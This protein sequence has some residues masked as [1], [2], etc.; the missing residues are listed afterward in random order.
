MWATVKQRIHQ[1]RGALIVAPAVAGALVALRLAGSLQLLELVALDQLFRLRPLEAADPRIVIVTIDEPDIKR[2]GRWPMSDAVLARLISLIKQQQP[3]AIGFDLF[4]NMPVEPGHQELLRIFASTKNLIGIEKVV[5]SAEGNT[6]EGPA[7]L[8]QRGQ[9]SASDFVLDIDGRLRRNLL[10]L[11]TENNQV[12]L[13]F[14]AKLAFTY[15]TSAGITPQDINLDKSQFRLGKAVFT[16]LQLNDGGYSQ[17]DAGG[18]QILSNF[19][20]LR[21][22]FHSISMTEV[23]QGQMPANLVRD[24]IVLIGSTAESV[25]DR[26]YTSFTVSP[27]TASAGV[28]VH[29]QLI[30]QL[31]SAAIEGRPL[32]RTWSEPLE[33]L[34]ILLWS[35]IG[36][37]WGWRFQSPRRTAIAVLL[38]GGVL[39]GVAYLLF[40][41]GWWLIVIPPSLALVTAASL[42]SGYQLWENLKLSHRQLADY[43][44]TLEQ[45]V[46]ERTEA[47]QQQKELL[48]TIVDHIPVMITLY[49]ADGRI[50]FINRELERCLG[51]S[52]VELESIDWLAECYLDPDQSQQNLEH[53]V[54]ATG[55]WLDLRIKAR[56]GDYLNITWANIPLSNG[57]SIGIGQDITERKQ[58]EEASILAS[59]L[60]ER[61]R[62]AREIHDTLA[63]TLTSIILQLEAAKQIV[64]EQPQAAQVH[65][66]RAGDF[67]RAGLAEAR[68]SVRALRPGVLEG[69]NLADALQRCLKQITSDGL[70]GAEF[71]VQGNSRPLAPDLEVELLRIGQEAMSNVLKHAQASRLSVELSFAADQVRLCIQD[72]GKGLELALPRQDCF[73]LISMQERVE[74]IG[75]Q[76]MITSSPGQGTQVIA[77]VSA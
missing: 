70:I 55:K 15:L 37:V 74:R 43:S 57:V 49:D 61:N 16:P 13:S 26:F 32:L 6:I 54:G 65:I 47:L 77:T 69:S 3:R 23:L 64:E 67:A 59:V 51:W 58:A 8:R 63:Q 52:Q 44:R 2:L 42:S 68:R 21:H 53:M 36:A 72:D 48:Q 12:I 17:T 62:M 46:A 34:W 19:R 76:L 4:R 56:S 71:C 28:E 73:G 60:E 40:L 39:F 27:D 29:A 5:S 31:L 38:G 45:Q 75:G 18:Y 24:R 14:G 33:G 9:V 7:I 30:S 22:G 1:W 41:A 35:A 66:G 11:R 50:L 25:N 20:R 10:Y